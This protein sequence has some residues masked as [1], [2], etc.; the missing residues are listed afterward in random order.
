MVAEK[1]MSWGCWIKEEIV[2]KSAGQVAHD[3][4]RTIS[5]SEWDQLA[6]WQKARWELV[7]DAVVAHRKLRLVKKKEKS[8]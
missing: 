4:W 5:G 6:G 2:E 1:L 3:T 8:Q 7:A